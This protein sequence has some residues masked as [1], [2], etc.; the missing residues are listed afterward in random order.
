MRQPATQAEPAPM[1]PAAAVTARRHLPVWLVAALLVLVT[2][3]I[4][5][6]ATR[7]DFVNYDDELHVT[8]NY[9]VQQGLTWKSVKWALVTPVNCIWH[10]ITVLSHMVDCQLFG[11]NPWGH[12]LTSVLLHAVNTMLV[13]LFLWGLTRALWPSVL[14]AALFGW[15]P[16]HVESVAWV[17][18]RKDLLSGLFGLLALMAYARYALGRR[19]K[20]ESRKQK[21]ESGSQNLEAGGRWSVVGSRWSLSQLP[22]PIF[23]L[24]ALCFLA[25]GLMSKPML[26]TWPFVMLLLDYWPLGRMQKRVSSGTSTLRSAT[27][28]GRHAPRTT[29]WRLVG[30]KIPFFILVALASVVTFLVQRHTGALAAGQSLP[31]GA[32][33]GNALISYARYLGKLFWPTDLAVV[34]PHPGQWPLAKVLLAGAV[35]LGLS[36]LFWAGRRRYP[37]LLMGWLWYC[38][39][40]VPVI[41]VVQTGSHAMADRY[42]Y[43]PALG[44]LI[45]MTWGM[46]ELTRGWRLQTLALAVAGGVV[47]SGCLVLTRQQVGYWRDSEALFRHALEVTENNSV[48]HVSLGVALVEKDQPDEAVDEFQ[49]ALR[50]KPDDVY[51]RYNLGIALLKSGKTDEAI[52]RL[53]EFLHLKPD[54]ADGHNHLGEAFAMKGQVDAAISQLRESIRLK[55]DNADARNNLGIAL[56]Q[57]GRTSE[58]MREF[59]EALRLK[60]AFADAHNYLGITL[61]KEA[62]VDEAISHY[63]EAL[64]LRPDHA[65]ARDNLGAALIKKGQIDEAMSQFREASRL[66]PGDADMHNNLGAA[67]EKK[68]QIDEAIREYLQAIHLK[69]DHPDA[70]NN[71]GNALLKKGQIDAVIGEFREAVRLKPDNADAH[72]NLGIALFRKHQI[73]EAIRQ[74][75]EAIRLKPDYASAFNNLGAAFMSKGQIDEAIRQFQQALRLKPDQANVHNNLG[76]ALG[77]SNRTREAIR[78]FQEALRLN[79]DSANARTNLEAALAT[80]ASSARLPGTSTNR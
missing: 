44:G 40:L 22:S 68:G 62:Q 67:L 78:E 14:A 41:Q 6:P 27:E 38:G 9:Q 80:Q 31:L 71:L 29:L 18:E 45:L 20:A 32:R 63:Q 57:N 58:A 75:Q 66:K 13:F 76:I 42:M 30:E 69:A 73:D 51:V 39:T 26:V 54:D 16:L 74:F 70:H 28:D 77:Q 55:P 50:L 10:P 1:G 37:C 59:Q 11:L 3:A 33:V 36:A 4:Y 65:H 53:Q 46:Y 7:C 49:E 48:A 25:L 61:F 72:Y 12:H 52:N 19:E 34:Y 35:I 79:P 15:H 21:A 64:R 8:A 47:I 43:L 5:W 56:G 2:I 60:P 17:S 24:L 23:Y